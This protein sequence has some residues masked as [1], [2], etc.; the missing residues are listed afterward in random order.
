M[1]PDQKPIRVIFELL[2]CY[3]V[4]ETD[5][6]DMADVTVIVKMDRQDHKT[7]PIASTWARWHTHLFCT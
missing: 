5:K 6:L 3:Q 1:I 7:Q 4:V 2:L